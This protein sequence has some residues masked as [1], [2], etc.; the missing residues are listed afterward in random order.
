LFHALISQKINRSIPIIIISILA[1]RLF[2]LDFFIVP[3]YDKNLSDK[4]TR[5]PSGG[6]PVIAECDTAYPQLPLEF[7]II[8]NTYSRSTTGNIDLRFSYRIFKPDGYIFSDTSG[9]V[10]FSGITPQ[11]GGW[12]SSNA[13]PKIIFTRNDK[14]G[15]YKLVITAIDIVTMA[16]VTQEKAIVLSTFP[17]VNASKFDVVSF[18]VWL[19][20]YCISPDPARAIAAF[21]YF[22][23]SDASNDDAIFWPVI[24]F[25]QCLFHENPVL[26][27]KLITHFPNSSSRVKEY[28]VFLLRS[29]EYQR[30]KNTL[31]PDSLWKK[32]DKAAETGFVEPF[33][34]ACASSSGQVLEFGF[35]YYGNYEM[36]RFL[37]ECL[38]LSTPSGYDTFRKHAQR[39]GQAC[40]QYIDKESAA[41]LSDMAKKII[42]KSYE[43]QLLIRTFCD[44]ALEYDD[45][46]ADSKKIL[47]DMI[48]H[49]P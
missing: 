12:I 27:S 39:Y 49:S 19:H 38:G 36:I 18:N 21:S 34:L 33:S 28:S 6:K 16:K 10:A 42:G 25:F 40:I 35:Y 41:K 4:L 29:I 7:H 32:F 43:K 14:P 3:S 30:E 1:T 26:V 13:I 48:A 11:N 45:I 44:Y 8:F 31:I 24:Y 22:I 23:S 20:S 46:S 2:A 15:I 17:K 47:G 5:Y 37:V 9:I